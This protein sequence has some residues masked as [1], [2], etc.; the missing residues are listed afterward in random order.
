MKLLSDILMHNHET[1]TELILGIK[2]Q[3][4]SAISQLYDDYSPALYSFIIKTVPAQDNAE[5]ILKA[6]FYKV[7][8][9]I[10]AYNLKGGSLFV[11]LLNITRDEVINTLLQSESVQK[12]KP[13]GSQALGYQLLPVEAF[14]SGLSLIEKTILSLRHCKDFSVGEISALLQLPAKLIERKLREALKKQKR[15]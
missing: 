13:S 9:D 3:K 2:N 7:W 12:L 6:V 4:H 14:Y 5:T 15:I 8:N 11:W 10:E 1:S